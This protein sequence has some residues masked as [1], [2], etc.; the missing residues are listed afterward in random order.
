MS[1]NPVGWSPC[2]KKGLLST[3]RLEYYMNMT[4]ST[5]A[6]TPYLMFEQ[7][8]AGTSAVLTQLSAAVVRHKTNDSVV[9]AI[10]ELCKYDTPLSKVV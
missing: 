2:H 7:H 5:R 9:D 6:F 4:L 3:A 10:R 1:T 8:S